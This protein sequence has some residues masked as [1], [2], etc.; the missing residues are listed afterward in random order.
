MKPYFSSKRK[1][2][3]V[4]EDIGAESEGERRSVRPETLTI[5]GSSGWTRKPTTTSLV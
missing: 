3:E 2:D 5:E 4:M 1:A